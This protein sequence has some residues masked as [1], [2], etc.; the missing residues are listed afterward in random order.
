MTTREN[1]SLR[2]IADDTYRL[3][4]N[5]DAHL[6][7]VELAEKSHVAYA[8]PMSPTGA[9][10]V[11]SVQN[12][13]LATLETSAAIS[14]SREHSRFEET[15]LPLLNRPLVIDDE[16]LLAAWC[17]ALTCHYYK[18]WA[19]CPK[20]FSGGDDLTDP[21]VVSEISLRVHAGLHLDGLIGNSQ[22]PPDEKI[23]ELTPAA[24]SV[25]RWQLDKW[26]EWEQTDQ[27][28][29]QHSLTN[30]EVLPLNGGAATS[31]A[32]VPGSGDGDLTRIALEAVVDGGLAGVLHA[33]SVNSSSVRIS[34]AISAM[35]KTN[36]EYLGWT[37]GD[38]VSH[39]KVSRKT[40]TDCD[41]WK[42]IMR[43]RRAR[44]ES[45]VS[46]TVSKKTAK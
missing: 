6:R 5:P 33:A 39:F 37:V 20:L 24:R 14:S 31:T 36:Q 43:T 11:D 1:L 2:A 41:A 4:E 40:I 23:P 3:L 12:K 44:K 28:S 7:L 26:M 42:E 15:P 34:A 38:W 45:R 32:V 8:Q 9:D 25:V 17:I 18:G 30:N 10:R 35:V 16:P 22:L 19:C 13:E 27:P 29:K 21:E 46:E